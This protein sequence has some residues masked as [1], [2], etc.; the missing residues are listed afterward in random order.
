MP[1]HYLSRG[2]RA[3]MNSYNHYIAHR[4]EDRAVSGAVPGAVPG[5]AA[6]SVDSVTFKLLNHDSSLGE[7]SDH[8]GSMS[9]PPLERIVPSSSD[10][11][12]TLESDS[13]S[14][15]ATLKVIEP[16]TGK[17]TPLCPGSLGPRVLEETAFYAP[18]RTRRDGSSYPEKNLNKNICFSPCSPSIS[19][20]SF[21]PVSPFY[22]PC[23]PPVS[24]SLSLFSPRFSPVSPCSRTCSINEKIPPIQLP[25][26]VIEMPVSEGS[27][28]KGNKKIEYKLHLKISD[29]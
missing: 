29:L 20:F 27:I 9:P 10:S 7:V 22:V 21:S 4:S 14:S 17:K 19:V 25:P 16:D 1:S 24:P 12:K 28:I 6:E 5:A 3:I 23:S 26:V 13:D 18:K 2:R 11:E 8:W 15:L